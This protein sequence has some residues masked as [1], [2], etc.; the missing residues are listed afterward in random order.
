LEH[1]ACE[2]IRE[3]FNKDKYLSVS[4]I[5]NNLYS[6]NGGRQKLIAFLKNTEYFIQ[7]YKANRMYIFKATDSFKTL[8]NELLE[9]NG[10]E[11]IDKYICDFVR[12]V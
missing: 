4:E 6:Y 7:E 10:E 2:R 5:Q 11:H 9:G 8:L 1:F 3:L 12:A